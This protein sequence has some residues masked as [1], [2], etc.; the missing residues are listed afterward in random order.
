[1]E[2]ITVRTLWDNGDQDRSWSDAIARRNVKAEDLEYDDATGILFS[3]DRTASAFVVSILQDGGLN[4]M[5][6]DGTSGADTITVTASVAIDASIILTGGD[7]SDRLR[8]E[9]LDTDDF[10]YGGEGHDQLYGGFGDDRLYGGTGNDILHGE[11]GDDRLYGGSGTDTLFG[12]EG[13][14]IIFGNEGNDLLIGHNGNDDLYGLDDDD[15]IIGGNGDDRIYG[16]DGEDTIFGGSQND[17]LEGGAGNDEL[18]GNNG[19][20]RVIGG[21]GEDVLYGDSG[22]DKLYGGDGNDILF[23]G[24]GRDLMYGNGGSDVFAFTTIDGNID[25]IQDFTLN[26]AEQDSLNITEIISGYS[27]LTSDI[28]DFVFFDVISSGRTDMM[29]NPNGSR[30]DWIHLVTIRGSNFS[31]TD[32]DD[33]LA[34]GQLILNEFAV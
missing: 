24:T 25:R 12:H 8:V 9:T 30:G 5:R 32:A 14:D 11:D 29:V 15:R 3:M 18:H 34:S 31:G 23:D 19:N 22:N 13:D 10:L 17:R 27:K 1:M 7:G 2:R 6:I 20:D 4:E 26:G 16:G 33:L 28:N 21:S